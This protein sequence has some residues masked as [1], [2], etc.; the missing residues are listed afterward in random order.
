[1]DAVFCYHIV[2]MLIA[3]VAFIFLWFSFATPGWLVVTFQE[4]EA[5]SEYTVSS[6]NRSLFYDIHCPQ[7]LKDCKTCA[8]GDESTQ[9]VQDMRFVQYSQH[10]SWIEQLTSGTEEWLAWRVIMI[11]VVVVC[12]IGF[13]AV[14]CLVCCIFRTGTYRVVAITAFFLWLI[15]GLL[16]WIPVGMAAHMHLQIDD[17]V[18]SNRLVSGINH[19]ATLHVPYSV[20]LAGLGGFF[21]L[22][23]ALMLL[24]LT[25]ACRKRE[26]SSYSDSES[27]DMPAV[28][29]SRDAR[30]YGPYPYQNPD[31]QLVYAGQNRYYPTSAGSAE[32]VLA[33]DFPYYKGTSAYPGLN[34]WYDNRS[35]L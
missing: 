34:A 5:R 3:T 32:E 21:S 35:A 7:E 27:K 26:E 14:L 4:A 12:S 1:M 19:D 24:W 22:I 18:N 16:V 17:D 8:A 2:L 31:R 11:I 29:R 33:N 9:C 25:G 23:A 6:L 15:G 20:V 28:I 30:Y 13:I 10:I